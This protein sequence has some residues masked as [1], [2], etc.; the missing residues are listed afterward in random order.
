M[1]FVNPV[2]NGS[3][4]S[5]GKSITGN[6]DMTSLFTTLLVAQIKNQ[7]PLS[8]TDPSE[9]VNQLTQLSQ[10]EALQSLSQQGSA[11][12]G[13]LSSLQMLSLGAQVGST[14]QVQVDQLKLDGSPVET[15]F[16][17][18]A[19]SAETRLVLTA[20]DGSEHRIELGSRSSGS[21]AYR[22]DPKAQGLP[23]GSYRVRVENALGQALPVEVQ[24]EM[25]GVRLAGNGGALLQ[26]G[27]LGEY[28][29]GAITQFKGRLAPTS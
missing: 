9:M 6:G 11:Q 4:A 7:D 8:P 2:S 12:A 25:T 15:R 26:L 22:L 18:P 29:P 14:V 20:A 16:N 17:L 10:M 3:G 21:Q 19:S 28:D 27:S 23:E 1:A 24:A 5:A 13:L